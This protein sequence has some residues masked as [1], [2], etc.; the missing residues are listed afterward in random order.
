MGIDI[1]V[2][3]VG[4]GMRSR[5]EE[6]EVGLDWEGGKM[7]L[8]LIRGMVV[9][10]CEEGGLGSNEWDGVV[11]ELEEVEVFLVFCGVIGE[12]VL[13]RVGEGF[14]GDGCEWFDGFWRVIGMGEWCVGGDLVGG[15]MGMGVW[16]VLEVLYGKVIIKC[17]G[18]MV[19]GVMGEKLGDEVGE[20]VVEW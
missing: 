2:E 13:E 5:I 7:G 20:N 14:G 16:G 12:R 18:K 17:V 4:E 10:G 19:E 9:V 3:R 1:V 8:V 15:R 6:D 11:Y